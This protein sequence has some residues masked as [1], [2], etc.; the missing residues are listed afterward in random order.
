MDSIYATLI[1]IAKLERQIK[2]LRMTRRKKLRQLETT[3]KKLAT[4][5]EKKG[6][7]EATLKEQRA[8]VSA[9]QATLATYAQQKK[10]AER[11]LFSG[12]GSAD[13]AQRQLDQ[14]SELSDALET[15]LLEVMETIDELSDA[16]EAAVAEEGEL[17]ESHEWATASITP[18]VAILDE[19]LRRLLAEKTEAEAPLPD[20]IRKHYDTLTTKSGS[21]IAVLG[22]G[23]CGHCHRVVP[24]SLASDVRRG[25]LISCD[26]CGR[27]L[28]A[29]A[30]ISKEETA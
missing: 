11:A 21:A 17:T 25:R 7:I 14:L 10:G 12:L 19:K 4:C 26:G 16:L 22:D 8:T 20:D 2:D 23:G 29:K 3:E 27:W 5:R 18:E 9:G 15:D 24:L 6:K 1:P 28:V 13:A 30:A